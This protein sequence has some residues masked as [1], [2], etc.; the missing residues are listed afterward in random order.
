MSHR[1]QTVPDVPDMTKR[2]KQRTRVYV[3]SDAWVR[4]KAYLLEHR[5]VT[6]PEFLAAA[7][8]FYLDSKAQGQS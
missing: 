2:N 4:A 8:H 1:G 3:L 5:H 7:I 6:M